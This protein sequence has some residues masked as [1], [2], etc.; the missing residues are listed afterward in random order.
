MPKEHLQ[1]MAAD[2]PHLTLL[3]RLDV[4]LA[5][6]VA[7]RGQDVD[8]NRPEDLRPEP[9][10]ADADADAVW[11]TGILALR[12]FKLRPT[13][14]AGL[15]RRG[16]SPPV[17]ADQET[18]LMLGMGTV[19]AMVRARA[20][21]GDAPDGWFAVELFRAL[22]CEIARFRANSLRRDEPWDGIF[23]VR[24][25]QADAIP[26]L[27]EGFCAAQGYGEGDRATEGM[28]PVRQACRL[29]WGF[30]RIAPFPDFNAV[31]AF[32]LMNAYLLA[33]G[34][35]MMQPERG[36]R[37]LVGQLIT[38]P[39]PQRIVQFESRLLAGVEGPHGSYPEP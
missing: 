33:K 16:F 37:Q 26:A 10:L 28:H 13:E 9:L 25:P 15:L 1:G 24:Y 39:R 8:L 17:G 27:L 21:G 6:R 12:G 35:P 23:G 3:E 11:I 14:A 18:R 30:A 34:Y 38:S 31:M 22:T 4:A 20:E 29:F 19:L 7:F 36:D 5:A 32:A 2:R